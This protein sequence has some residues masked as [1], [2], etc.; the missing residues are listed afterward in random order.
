MSEMKE[1][2]VP[3]GPITRHLGELSQWIAD[4]QETI[5]QLK[6]I[7]SA[8]QE[9]QSIFT[10]FADGIQQGLTV[11]QDGNIVWANEA[12]CRMFGY[13]IS[14]LINTSGIFM[15]PA[16]YREKLAVR[17]AE[18]QAGDVRP[19]YDI[20]PFVA[21][22]GEVKQVKSYANRII[23]GGRPAILAILV[24]ATAEQ[25]LHDELS[26]RAQMLDSVW[27]SVFL[28][29]LDGN[30][31]YANKAACESL[32]YTLDEIIKMNVI[33]INPEELK[34]RA[35]SRLKTIPLEKVSRFKTVRVRRNGSRMHVEVRSKAMKMADKEY[36]LGVVREIIPEGL[37]DI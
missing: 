13:E 21:K 20:W 7:D 29:D 30:I 15:A 9:L 14:E 36:I 28:H 12:G 6:S 2:E 26:I 35:R 24:D 27:D 33:D 8:M 1:Q 17:L 5:I 37:Q 34:R 11:V 19:T 31:K 4:F 16:A 10:G 22:N 18:I 3:Y 23:Y 32:G 25:K